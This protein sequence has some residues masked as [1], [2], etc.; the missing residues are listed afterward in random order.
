MNANQEWIQLELDRLKTEFQFKNQIA[1]MLRTTLADLKTQRGTAGYPQA[2][3]PGGSPHGGAPVPTMHSGIPVPNGGILQG[4]MGQG[5]GVAPSG[6]PIPGM[7]MTHSGIPGPS[8]GITQGGLQMP[9]GSPHV[10][11]PQP[12]AGM[13][14]HTMPGPGGGVPNMG[15][16]V[17]QVGPPGM[18][19][20]WQGS[21]FPHG[22]S[23]APHGADMPSR[24]GARTLASPS[25]SS[26]EL[27]MMKVEL[28]KKSKHI[29]Q[30][31][32]EISTLEAQ[33]KVLSEALEEERHEN[34]D[35]SQE[36]AV[37]RGQV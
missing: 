36:N 10:G 2:G 20:A 15:I 6:V 24:D 17:P 25:T 1:S 5:G 22:Y 7:G 23:G 35:L 32:A 21:G 30:L 18:Q 31:L 27:A 16:P 8:S 11:I 14:Q 33:V 19:S 28:E 3:P 37:L 26:R 12:G 13:S 34:S 29:G 9:G 4:N